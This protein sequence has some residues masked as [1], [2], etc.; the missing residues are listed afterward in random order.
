MEKSPLVNELR[1]ELSRRFVIT[2][3]EIPLSR[4]LLVPMVSKYGGPQEAVLTF[5]EMML[6]GHANP[7]EEGE[8][9]LS[10]LSLLFDCEV[11]KTGYRVNSIDISGGNRRQPRLADHFEANIIKGDYSI[12]IENIFT[13]SNQLAK[14]FVRACNAYSLAISSVELDSSLSFL[15]LVTAL[16]CIS[17]QEEFLPNTVLDKSKKGAERY[18]SLVQSYCSVG[19]DPMPKSEENDFI[20]DLKTVYYSH[21][22]AFVHGGR[23]VSVASRIADQAGFNRIGHFV[24][25]EEVFTPG[26]KWFFQVTRSTLLGFLAKHPRV[27]NERNPLVLSEIASSRAVVTLRVGGA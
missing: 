13:L 22:S 15:L 23:E 3:S 17:T 9:V 14:Q 8:I 5:E 2:Q 18:C 1:C 16:E 20:R 21:R 26:L 25:G 7:E 4:Y 6:K 27:S 11:K 19:T 12:D 10:V 24:E